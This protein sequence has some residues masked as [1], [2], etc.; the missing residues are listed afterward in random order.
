[1]RALI[2]AVTVV[3]AIGC[4]GDRS[5]PLDATR[6]S[7]QPPATADQAATA[8]APFEVTLDGAVWAKATPKGEAEE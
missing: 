4:G 1:M 6:P 3:L 8:R 5:E 2:C 7:P